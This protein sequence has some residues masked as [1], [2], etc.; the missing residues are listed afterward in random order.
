MKPETWYPD[1][2]RSIVSASGF[3]FRPSRKATSSLISH[4]EHLG[5]RRSHGL[6]NPRGTRCMQLLL[7]GNTSGE[8]FKN[9]G[10]K[11]RRR[12]HVSSLARIL[13]L[14]RTV[15]LNVRSRIVERLVPC[16]CI[17]WPRILACVSNWLSTLLG[18]GPVILNGYRVLECSPSSTRHRSRHLEWVLYRVLECMHALINVLINFT[19]SLQL[20][21]M[22]NAPRRKL[23]LPTGSDVGVGTLGNGSNHVKTNLLSAPTGNT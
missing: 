20:L 22:L 6:S 8:K 12:V 21:R 13:E 23:P 9:T 18:I 16:S 7:D 1:A 17:V 4:K 10:P 11:L 3:S 14:V 2:G 19:Q 15:Y 5:I